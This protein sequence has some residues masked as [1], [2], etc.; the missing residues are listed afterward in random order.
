M[1]RRQLLVFTFFLFT[2]AITG[3]PGY[4]AKKGYIA[5][6][7]VPGAALVTAA[8]AKA[9]HDAGVVFI[10]VRSPRLYNRRHIPGVVHLDLKDTFDEE[11]LARVAK[12]DQP[13]V[14]YCSGIKCSRSSTASADAVSWGFK[15]V[16]YF[17]GGI[18]EW[19]DAGYPVESSEVEAEQI[20][21]GGVMPGSK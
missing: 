21:P 15:K 20:K 10:D 1:N 3:Q 17:R 19:R 7:Q 11:S 14:I 9:L 6:E 5:P 12:K 8:E 4:A 13:L 18:V 16:H 2:Y